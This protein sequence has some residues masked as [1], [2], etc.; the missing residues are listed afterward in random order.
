MADNDR[1]IEQLK[2][3]VGETGVL[4]DPAELLAY[5]CDGFPIARGLPGAVVFPTTTPQV[6][7]CVKA[8]NEYGISLIPRGSGT[9]LTGGCAA[10]DGGVILC[11]SRM[12]RI[13]EINVR[14]RTALVEAG[15]CNTAL[16]DQVNRTP[17][18]ENLHFSPDPSSERASTIAGNVATNAGGIHTLKHGVTTNHVL[19]VEMVLADGSVVES[20]LDSLYE[21]IGPDIP[22]LICGCEGTLGIVTKVRVR[23]TARPRAFRTIVGIFHS[24]TDACRTVSD[25]IAGGIVPA[26]MEIMDGAMVKVVED[27]FGY[28]FPADAGALLLI[29]LDGIEAALDE[30]VDAVVRL[31]KTNHADQVQHSADAG[32]RAELWSA[33]KRAFG[34]IGRISSGYC[35]QDACV[36][37]SKLPEVVEHVIGIGRKHGLTITNVF[38][39]GDG[40][41]HP[42]LLFDED[43]PAD[44]VRTMQASHDILEYCIS[45]GGTL[46]GEHGVGVE[47][48]PMMK[49]MFDQPTLNLFDR[50]KHTFDPD[51]RINVGKLLP[52]DKLFVDLLKPATTNSPGGAL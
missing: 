18:G 11:T 2:Q 36:P 14:S 39:A 7:R 45:I 4:D 44:I 1:L 51:E 17:G 21:G 24:T 5:E 13:L 49:V 40:N 50:I 47:K 28:G 9:G 6:A 41:V 15:V 23:L 42:I 16:T 34:A 38:H 48:L 30:Q 52:S 27:A 25:V 26:A 19:G 37:R 20:R 10:F 8:L 29:E 31:C 43:D 12:N 46:T 32:R 3:V 33:R 35:T 22:A